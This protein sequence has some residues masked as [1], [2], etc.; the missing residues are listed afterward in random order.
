VKQENADLGIG[1][2]GDGDRLGVV[3]ANGRLIFADE[4]M[5]YFIED[6][7]TKHKDRKIIFDIKCSNSISQLVNELGGQPILSKTGHSIIK[8]KIKETNAIMAGEMSG[9]IFFNDR[10]YGHDDALYA[11]CRLLELIANSDKDPKNYFSK[12]PVKFNTPELKLPVAEIQKET[13]LEDIKQKLVASFTYE[14]AYDL[15]G[16]R[17]EASDYWLLIRA[18]NTT[19][20]LIAR[21]EADTEEKLGELKAKFSEIIKSLGIDFEVK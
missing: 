1:F 21:I 5:K 14:K 10:W 4:Y 6:I 13:V 19:A 20:N 18:S 3:D 16:I 8:D 7:L 2:D 17:L 15:D 9:H 11:A 12:F